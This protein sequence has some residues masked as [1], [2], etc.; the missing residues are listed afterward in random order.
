VKKFMPRVWQNSRKRVRNF[1]PFVDRLHAVPAKGDFLSR[2]PESINLKVPGVGESPRREDFA[3]FAESRGPDS[4]VSA[5][6]YPRIE[7]IA[8]HKATRLTVSNVL[9]RRLHLVTLAGTA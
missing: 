5:E 4:A 8:Q 3:R 6:S 7:E 2:S 9:R 1:A